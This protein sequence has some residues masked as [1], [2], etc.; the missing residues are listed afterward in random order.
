[1]NL[2][3]KVSVFALAVAGMASAAYIQIGGSNGLTQSYLGASNTNLNPGG[4]SPSCANNV[5]DAGC[6]SERSYSA[7]LY[8]NAT[9]GTSAPSGTT[10]TD[11]NG[12]AFNLITD[13]TG[14]GS[15]PNNFWT[16]TSAFNQQYNLTVPINLY[17]VTNLYTMLNL[18]WGNANVNDVSVLFNFCQTSACTGGTTSQV[19]VN[20][21]NSNNAGAGV[22]R[23]GLDCKVAGTN[24]TPTTYASGTLANTTYTATVTGVGAGTASIP[25]SVSTVFTT[26]F[27]GAGGQYVGAT[28]NAVLDDQGFNFNGT[29]FSTEYLQSI[30]I[31]QTNNAPGDGLGSS[32]YVG[33]DFALSAV[34]AAVPEPSTVLLMLSGL[35]AF[36]F[37]RLRRK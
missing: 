13:G 2:L 8:S 4:S 31:R 3:T 12:V 26:G 16:P 34:T 22:L 19:T 37:K 27:S 15:K 25:V 24:C 1:M 23:D 32:S 18:M 36:G 11:P 29:A 28:G 17:N 6:I 30:V 9:L 5:S 21:I 33:S 10:V 20:L 14:P 7:T 35:G